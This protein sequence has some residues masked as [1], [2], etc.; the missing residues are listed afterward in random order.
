MFKTCQLNTRQ[1]TQAVK[2]ALEAPA[3]NL[4]WFPKFSGFPVE[5]PWSVHTVRLLGSVVFCLLVV[6]A[7]NTRS[8]I[9]FDKEWTQKTDRFITKSDNKH[10][11]LSGDSIGG[12]G[13]R[14]IAYT[15]NQP[16]YLDDV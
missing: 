6:L 14:V 12:F 7:V 13:P 5:Q 11:D 1:P 3:M 4:Y 8:N 10:L 16:A 15:S 9:V 2:K